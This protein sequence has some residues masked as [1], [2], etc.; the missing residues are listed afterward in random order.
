[1]HRMEL[2]K[3][4]RVQQKI[5]E[6][7]NEYYKNKRV[8]KKDDLAMLN[9]MLKVAVDLFPNY[10]V[11]VHSEK[12]E[13]IY[14]SENVKSSLFYSPKSITNLSDF[15]FIENI[16]PDDLKPVR[17][18]MEQIYDLGNEKAYDHTT[19]RYRMNLR[20][21]IENDEYAHI[22]YE[23]ITIQYEGHFADLVLIKNITQ[24]QPFQHVELVVFKRTNAGLIKIKQ[25]IPDQKNGTFT[26][27]EKDIIQLL[28][29]GFSNNNIAETLGISISTVK[30]H[31][32][33]LFRKLNVK[34]S[35]QLMDY[36]RKENIV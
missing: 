19:I 15:E 18:V 2:V 30:N 11:L 22:L 23:A 29:K 32:G 20:Y 28:G 1:M 21:K 35:L 12:S 27:R 26:P 5:I 6:Q 13:R 31:R 17:K 25:F 7:S 10:I 36:V 16:H 9:T 8:V 24:E 3:L 34:N 14:V 33:K 4:Y